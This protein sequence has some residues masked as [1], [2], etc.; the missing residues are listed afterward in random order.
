M[1]MPRKW[2]GGGILSLKIVAAVCSMV[3]M[4]GVVVP[5]ALAEAPMGTT[6]DVTPGAGTL[7]KAVE[8]ASDGDILRLKAGS[9]TGNWNEGREV[10]IDKSITIE[11]AGVGNTTIDVPLKITAAD[12]EV[13]L[14]NFGSS[15]IDVE[16]NFVYVSVDQ[17]TKLTI[18]N[19]SIWGILRGENGIYPVH[20]AT[21]ISIKPEANGSE[22]TLNNLNLAKP[23]VHYGILNKA[24]NTTIT[25][26]RGS[27]VEGRTTIQFDE[28]SGNKLNVQG[29]AEVAG[30]SSLYTDNECIVINRQT[31]LEINLDNGKV[32]ATMSKGSGVAKVFA[33]DAESTGTKINLKNGSSISYQARDG[34]TNI[35]STIFDFDPTTTTDKG[36]EIT[37]DNTSRLYRSVY[38]NRYQ[39]VRRENVEVEHEYSVLNNAAV[40]GVFDKDGGRTIKIYDNETPIEEVENKKYSNESKEGYN[41]KGWFKRFDGENYTDEFAKLGDESYPKAVT[42]TNMDLYPKFLKRV[43]VKIGVEDFV[44]E[45]GQNLNNI[46]GVDVDAKLEALK[47][48]DRN[49]RGYVMHGETGGG[50]SLTTE[51]IEEL[52]QQII[53]ED[54]IIEAIHDVTIKVNNESFRLDVGQTVADIAD[55]DAYQAAKL[56]GQEEKYFSRLVYEGK[57]TTFEENT[58]INNNIEVVTKHYLTVKI[59]GNDAEYLVEEGKRISEDKYGTLTRDLTAIQEAPVENKTFG[60]FI[61]SNNENAEVNLESYTINKNATIKPIY[62]VKVRIGAHDYTLDEGQKLSQHT[63]H[64]QIEAELKQLAQDVKAAGQELKGFVLSSGGT[65]ELIEAN[66]SDSDE[67]I[68]NILDK[69]IKGNT[70]IYAKYMAKIT[71]KCPESA[72]DGEQKEFEVETGSKLIDL[73]E[74]AKRADYEKAKYQNYESDAENRDERFAGFV[75]EGTGEVF[76][77]NQEIEK[78]LTLTPKYY[79]FVTI[80]DER[81]NVGGK[82]KIEIGKD[83]DEMVPMSGQVADTMTVLATL[84]SDIAPE[85]GADGQIDPNAED[86]H[87]DKLVRSGTKELL[88]ETITEDISIQGLYHYDVI[89]VEDYDNPNQD[90]GGVDSGLYGFKVYRGEGLGDVEPEN[91]SKVESALRRLME[92]ATELEQGRRFYRFYDEKLNVTYDGDA[93]KN[94]IFNRHLYITAKVEY[95]VAVEGDD[96]EYYVVDGDTI[97]SSEAIKGAMKALEEVADKKF[98]SYTLNG[99]LM[100]EADLLNTAVTNGTNKI[101]AKYNVIVTIGDETFEI[102]E[103]ESL[104]S[105]EETD[106]QRA[107]AALQKLENEVKNKEQEFKGYSVAESLEEVMGYN[108]S[109]NTEVAAK[110]AIKVTIDRNEVGSDLQTGDKLAEKVDL[111]TYKNNREDGRVFSRFVNAKGETFDENAPLAKNE[112]LTTKY[113]FVVTIDGDDSYRSEEGTL[114][115]QDAK[116]AGKLAE[117]KIAKPEKTFGRFEDEDTEEEVA[118]D[119]ILTKNVKIK[120]IYM[121]TIMIGEQ[122]YVIDEGGS[123]NDLVADRNLVSQLNALENPDNKKFAKYVVDGHE[124]DHDG[125]MSRKFNDNATVTVKYNVEVKI[126][127]QSVIL[128]EGTKYADATELISMINNLEVPGNKARVAYVVD[129]GSR[130]LSDD[131]IFDVNTE[132]AP[133]YYVTLKFEG[134]DEAA[135]L[136][137]GSEVKDATDL[138]AKLTQPNKDFKEFEGGKNLD[139][140]ISENTTLKPLYTVT[141]TVKNHDGASKLYTVDEGTTLQNLIDGPYE[142]PEGFKRFEDLDGNELQLSDE[143]HEHKTIIP[144]YGITVTLPDGAGETLESGQSLKDLGEEKLSNAKLDVEGRKFSRFVNAKTGQTVT[145][146]EPLYESLAIDPRFLNKVTITAQDDN[147]QPV[148]GSKT[149]ELELEEGLPLSGLSEDQKQKLQDWINENRTLLEKAGRPSYDLAYYLDE[150]GDVM[151][152][153]KVLKNNDNLTAVFAYTPDPTPLPELNLEDGTN[154]AAAPDTGAETVSQESANVGSAIITI[155]AILGIGASAIIAYQWYKKSE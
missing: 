59:E 44:L 124:L 14:K 107:E 17:K 99:S 89:V 9:Y 105:L 147:G 55:K 10:N 106:K 150:N 31:G 46:Q 30:P 135:E 88:D 56:D 146:D 145:E 36:H 94:K 33:I 125:L 6:K 63:D 149:L 141:V 128:P 26:D 152:A 74:T 104:N 61:D 58:P 109:Q 154:N 52:K 101:D 21:G 118:E 48:D 29:D 39:E 134:I 138:V 102:A 132:L 113:A 13:T 15:I 22:I 133:K 92:T 114:L 130:Q 144:I 38:D 70:D 95:K 66:N 28:G 12:K 153:D 91:L 18:E 117:L 75:V 151:Q 64:E 111:S 47:E 78:S 90:F 41:F 8:G 24:S 60:R 71:I 96:S 7:K 1:R 123:L 53:T 87:F 86:L 126:G 27:M 120:P 32:A 93:L 79:A 119:Q 76:A 37:L 110:A 136:V 73:L 115:N 43:K 57:D 81:P 16:K 19:V 2:R 103:G 100:Q 139:T 25:L 140:V 20:D 137:E 97:G 129:G 84:R 50:I 80:D 131:Y 51:N 155:L 98:T 11:G 35:A 108:F 85:V 127:G 116:I 83:L 112:D 143:L 82:Y 4:V 42:G 69:E 142:E 72:C 122:P 49:F 121:V 54:V 34:R 148:E 62:T 45:E 40:V 65:E 23:G 3:A 5:A 67:K 77:E 68:T